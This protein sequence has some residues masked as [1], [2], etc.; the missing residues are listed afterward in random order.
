MCVYTWVI[1][2]RTHMPRC[3]CGNQHNLWKF[4]FFFLFFSFRPWTQVFR[5]GGQCLHCMSHLSGLKCITL[6]WDRGWPWT[7]DFFFFNSVYSFPLDRISCILGWPKLA[8]DDLEHLFSSPP[9]PPSP[10]LEITQAC[11]IMPHWCSA[12]DWSQ[13]FVHVNKQVF[14]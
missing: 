12:R 11:A 3:I 1:M 5:L 4:F 13:G 14:Y 8:N 6:L 7:S 9:P 2:C 10:S